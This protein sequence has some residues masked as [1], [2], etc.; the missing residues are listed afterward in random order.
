MSVHLFACA[1][2]S[3]Q[4]IKGSVIKICVVETHNNLSI[5]IKHVFLSLMMDLSLSHTHRHNCNT[6]RHIPTTYDVLTGFKSLQKT[7]Q[8]GMGGCVRKC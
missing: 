2:I 3:D 1:L 4:S 6:H 5:I 7:G 8:E